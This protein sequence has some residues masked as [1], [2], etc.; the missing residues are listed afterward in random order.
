MRPKGL[1]DRG[2]AEKTPA[3]VTLFLVLWRNVKR[4]EIGLTRLNAS[5]N[6]AYKAG[7]V[8]LF[9]FGSVAGIE[10]KLFSLGSR[11]SLINL[12][13]GAPGGGTFG[14]AEEV[15]FGKAWHPEG[16]FG[17]LTGGWSKGSS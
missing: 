14:R 11:S 6:V 2:N 17:I 12:Q 10:I 4:S 8:L 1:P 16:A 9:C 7:F 5:V 13:G 3:S 15:G